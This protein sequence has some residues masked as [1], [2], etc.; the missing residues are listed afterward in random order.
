MS[1]IYLHLLGHVIF[2][3]GGVRLFVN[4]DLVYLIILFCISLSWR[5]TNG[6]CVLDKTHENSGIHT[7]VS[8][9]TGVP[10]NVLATLSLMIIY[11]NLFDIWKKT[12][13]YTHLFIL[14]IF[15]L[16]NPYWYL[17]TV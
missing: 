16:H 13:S 10:A 9:W 12:D 3:F 7:H 2:S 5:F 1:F 8:Q 11:F 14:I 6:Q 17:Q 4:C 15:V